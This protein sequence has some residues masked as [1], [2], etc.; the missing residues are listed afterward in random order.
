MAAMLQMLPEAQRNQMA[1]AL[2]LSQEQ[3]AQMTQ[4][5]AAIPPQQLA[6]MMAGAGAGAGGLPPG[7]HVVQLTQEEMAAVRRLQE[8]GFSQQQAVEAFIACDRNEAL[9]ANFLFDG[10]A[11]GDD[12][13]GDYGDDGGDDMYN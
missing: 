10:G 13:G 11:F 6:Q 3:L 2:G 7:A 8:L 5:M 9:A 1:A 12:D 4:A